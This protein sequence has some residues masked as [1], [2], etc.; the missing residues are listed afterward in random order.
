[1]VGGWVVD[2]AGGTVS[3]TFSDSPIGIRSFVDCHICILPIRSADNIPIFPCISPLRRS[4]HPHFIGV[5]TTVL[6]DCLWPSTFIIPGLVHFRTSVTLR[7]VR[8][9]GRSAKSSPPREIAFLPLLSF[10]RPPTH[11]HYLLCKTT[12]AKEML[13]IIDDQQ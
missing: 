4:A 2:T 9:R 10:H 7:R 6:N 11:L 13:L 1:M 3:G 5:R 12:V 8:V